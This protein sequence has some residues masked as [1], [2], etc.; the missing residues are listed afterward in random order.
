MACKKYIT[1]SG[2]NKTAIIL[3][4]SIVKLHLGYRTFK[5]RI[6]RIIEINETILWCN[7]GVISNFFNSKTMQDRR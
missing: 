4:I 5:D 7:E 2:T 3:A 6:Y 1:R